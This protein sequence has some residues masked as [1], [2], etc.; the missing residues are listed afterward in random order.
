MSWLPYRYSAGG[1]SRQHTPLLRRVRGRISVRYSPYITRVLYAHS[2]G[3][4]GVNNKRQRCSNEDQK[5][6]KKPSRRGV[7]EVLFAASS[8][9]TAA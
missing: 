2:G 6:R 5:G 8:G 9:S 4:A 3:R 7:R 1:P